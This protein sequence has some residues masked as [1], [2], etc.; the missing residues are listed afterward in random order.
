AAREQLPAAGQA[1]R[2]AQVNDAANPQKVREQKARAA[3]QLEAGYVIRTAMC[4]EARDGRLHVFLPP[5]TYLEQYVALIEAIED[6][7]AA[8]NMPVVLEGYEPPKDYRLKKFLITPDPGV[9]EVNIHPTSNW[10]ELV[11]NTEAL[12][13][14][15]RQCRLAT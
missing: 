10:P 5:V 7:A 8:L 1:Y 15:A 6:T 11:A 3:Q 2:P 9:I 13:E 14:D 12:Y 4:F